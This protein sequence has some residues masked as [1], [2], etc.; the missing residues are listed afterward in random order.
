MKAHARPESGEAISQEWYV[1][2]GKHGEQ[3]LDNGQIDQATE[4]FESIL[5]RLGNAPTYGRAVILGR[6]GRCFYTSGRHD[7][8]VQHVRT[9]L[10]LLG[11]LG[12]SEGVKRLRGT[13]R[14]ELGDALRASG[15]HG[16]AKKAYEAALKIAEELNDLRSQGVDLARLGALALTEG[17]L[18]DALT[19][20][21]A[22]RRLF[23]RLHEPEMEAA[24]CHQLG[25]VYHKQHQSDE[26]ERHYREAAR[27]NEDRGRLDR[28]AQTWN[29]LADLLQNQSDR[30]A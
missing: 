16:D 18:E 11:R 6:L 4:I 28:A 17:N 9:A 22:A 19:R 12:P 13:L 21:L 20:H 26:A 27:I 24:A 23:Q 1:A 3:L 8:A 30:V 14:S 2:G 5:T 10:D 29:D 25:T 15:H 7:L